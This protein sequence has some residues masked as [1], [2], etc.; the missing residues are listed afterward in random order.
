MK[1]ADFQEVCRNTPKYMAL[2]SLS[3]PTPF[4]LRQGFAKGD[5][6]L[7]HING[8]MIPVDSNQMSIGCHA[9]HFSFIGYAKVRIEFG[10]QYVVEDIKATL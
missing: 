1:K 4:H 10:N 3:K 2:F 9:S 5:R 8:C 6:F 7:Y